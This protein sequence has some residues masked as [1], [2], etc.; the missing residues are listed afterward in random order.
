L[1][2]PAEDPSQCLTRTLPNFTRLVADILTPVDRREGLP[3]IGI[4]DEVPLESSSARSA[5]KGGSPGGLRVRLPGNCT[6]N[7]TEARIVVVQLVTV[8]VPDG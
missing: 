8:E 4:G 2:A 7:E 5:V 1:V 6:G 3:K